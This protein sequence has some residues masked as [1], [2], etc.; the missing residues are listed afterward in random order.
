VGSAMTR[1]KRRNFVITFVNNCVWGLVVDK[2]VDK[3]FGIC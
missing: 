3:I 1:Y 2:I